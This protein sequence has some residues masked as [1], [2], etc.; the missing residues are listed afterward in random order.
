MGHLT[1]LIIPIFCSA[2]ALNAAK[3]QTTTTTPTLNVSC[4]PCQAGEAPVFYGNGYKAR[5]TVQLDIVGP[6]SYSIMVIVDSSGNFAVD[7]GTSLSFTT[8]TYLATA[9]T[10]S[11]KRLTLQDSVSFSVE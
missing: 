11:G 8:G 4:D 10:I 1:R 5:S 2:L 3:S 7:Y 9:S 6:T